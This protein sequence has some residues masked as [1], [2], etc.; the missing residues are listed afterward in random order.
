M[1][2]TQEAQLDLFNFCPSCGAKHIYTAAQV[3]P[4]EVWKL[5][6]GRCLVNFWNGYSKAIWV[7]IPEEG[8]RWLAAQL[9]EGID[10]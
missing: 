8:R 5:P 3:A 9:L 2:V 7:E 1:V 10:Q 6:D 4:V